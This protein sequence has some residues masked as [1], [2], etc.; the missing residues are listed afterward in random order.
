MQCRHLTPIQFSRG[1][2]S[3][4][5]SNITSTQA[6]E[7]CWCTVVPRCVEMSLEIIPK[8][9]DVIC[10]RYLRDGG[11]Q[12]KYVVRSGLAEVWKCAVM[13]GSFP[14][15]LPSCFFSVA[16]R[17]HMSHP[18]GKMMKMRQI[19]MVEIWKRTL[20]STPEGSNFKFCHSCLVQD[21]I[22]GWVW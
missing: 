12:V 16:S 6:R 11:C 7:G 18:L 10:E 9:T 15:F 21:S 2:D 19:N 14:S 8:P 3:K 5:G 17:T 20:L 13:E 22:L 1:G 4:E